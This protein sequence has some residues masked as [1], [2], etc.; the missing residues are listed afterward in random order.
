MIYLVYW[1]SF[2]NFIYVILMCWNYLI[3]VIDLS[4]PNRNNRNRKTK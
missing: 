4:T 3:D 2:T 1:I